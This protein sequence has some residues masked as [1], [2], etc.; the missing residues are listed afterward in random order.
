MDLNKQDI[1]NQ[2]ERSKDD[3]LNDY[4]TIVESPSISAL[5]SHKPYIKE[6]A[7]IAVRLIEKHGGQAQIIPTSGNPVV[8]GKIENDPQAETIAIYNH[9]DVQ[10]AEKG[11]DGWTRD[12]FDF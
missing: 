6:T 9:L 10:P 3:L 8:Y 5:Q 1:A 12:P 11:K 4:K 2:I 7:E